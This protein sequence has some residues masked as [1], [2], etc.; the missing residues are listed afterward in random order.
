MCKIGSECAGVAPFSGFSALRAEK[1]NSIAAG[2]YVID[3]PSSSYCSSYC[4]LCS[5]CS[6]CYSSYSSWFTR[7]Q[8]S[9]TSYMISCYSSRESSRIWQ[10]ITSG[11]SVP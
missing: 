10:S 7:A 11:I 6:Y 9:P 5:S 3:V 8:S 1:H 2:T 4:S